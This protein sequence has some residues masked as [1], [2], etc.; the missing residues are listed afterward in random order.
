MVSDYI[1][2]TNKHV[3]VVV[4]S[5]HF[6]VSYSLELDTLV[7]EENFDGG[8][9]SITLKWPQSIPQNNFSQEF[10]Q[11]MLDRMAMG[12]HNY[13][14]V[15]KNFPHNYDALEN[16]KLRVKKYKKTHNTEW[17]MDAA[18]FLMIEFMHPKDSK[19]FFESTSK[20]ESPGSLLRNKK[21]SKGKEDFDP[22]KDQ[23]IIR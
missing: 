15:S 12:F 6:V 2:K 5:K 7:K 11:G 23:R 1:V 16:V 10:I 8:T 18:N 19:A 20:K 17:L 3:L 9:M 13:G 14:H 21:L 22:D 4:L